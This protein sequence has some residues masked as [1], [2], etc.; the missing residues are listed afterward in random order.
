M[1][2]NI[3]GS[4]PKDEDEHGN[5]AVMV[6]RTWYASM[7]SG[8]GRILLCFDKHNTLEFDGQVFKLCDNGGT[9]VVPRVVRQPEIVGYLFRLAGRVYV[10]D[11]LVD[12][13]KKMLGKYPKNP[14]PHF[15]L[16]FNGCQ[17]VFIQNGN[18]HFV[19]KVHTIPDT[20]EYNEKIY[21]VSRH[22]GSTMVSD[23]SKKF[24]CVTE[25]GEWYVRLVNN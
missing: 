3:F 23:G 1:D 5:F 6:G 8:H 22:G 25:N 20:F 17:H 2:K 12:G 16:T 10:Y 4:I 13:T 18:T 24:M 19:V 11:H 15:V 7:P 14:T 9:C 21:T